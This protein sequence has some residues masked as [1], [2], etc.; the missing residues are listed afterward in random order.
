MGAFSF[1]TRI[2]PPINGI[3]ASVKEE[4]TSWTAKVLKGISAVL[5][6]TPNSPPA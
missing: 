1:S 6:K 3:F 4:N 5:R 2:R